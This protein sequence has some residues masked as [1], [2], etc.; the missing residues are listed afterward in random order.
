MDFTNQIE[1]AEQ[2][3][4]K[5]K[6]LQEE[7]AEELKEARALN[8]TLRLQKEE[9]LDAVEKTSAELRAT[10]H[11]IQTQ[12]NV[13]NETQWLEQAEQNELQTLVR[14]K[15]VTELLEKQTGFWEFCEGRLEGLM[16]DLNVGLEG[17]LEDPKDP[18][19]ILKQL[20]AENES[21]RAFGERAVTTRQAINF[22]EQ[23]LRKICEAHV[24]GHQIQPALKQERFNICERYFHHRL[25]M[26]MWG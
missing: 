21:P 2:S 24:D 8:N 1:K 23:N 25:I 18:A 17:I 12:Q 22:Y 6:A 15:K 16:S 14:E 13:L 5:L 19:E 3:I 26:S 9:Q 4:K 10:V 20:K 11:T 7:A